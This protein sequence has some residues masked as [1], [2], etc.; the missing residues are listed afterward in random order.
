MRC[1]LALELPTEVKVRLGGLSDR[2]RPHARGVRWVGAEQLH[3]T[4][5]FF[6]EVPPER[7]TAIHSVAGPLCAR[8]PAIPVSVRGAGSFGP[9]GA[10]R[11]LWAGIGDDAGALSDFQSELESGLAGAGFPR[12]ERPFSPH[13]TLGRA[14]EPKRDPALQERLGQEASFDGGC[15]TAHHLTLF[16][17]TLTPQGAVYKVLGTWSF[18]E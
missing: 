16:A 14:R 17:S 6:G 4:L 5:H 10:A 3:L 7:L 15:F 8:T 13:L 12:E 18:G 2:L 11:V 9:A 1:F